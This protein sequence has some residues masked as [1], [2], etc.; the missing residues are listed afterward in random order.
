M[1]KMYHIPDPQD[2]FDNTYMASFE[3]KNPYP[4]KLIQGWRVLG[5]KIKF[6]KLSMYIITSLEN[7]YNYEADMLC[8]LYGLPN[9]SKFSIEWIPLIDAYVNS[10]AMNWAT[11]LFDNLA[12]II[13]T[14]ESLLS[15]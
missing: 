15:K 1:K 12:T 14:E 11:I 9:N 6:E 2:I 3:N 5:K 7:P 8:R 10:H 4:F 13:S